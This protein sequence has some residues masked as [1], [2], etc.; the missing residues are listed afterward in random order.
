MSQTPCCPRPRPLPRQT[1]R[2]LTMVEL[3][4]CLCIS[5]LLL[6]GAL[7]SLRD[8]RLRQTLDA[9]AAML[10][11]DVQ[12]ARSLARATDRTVRLAVQATADGGSCYVIHSGPAGACSCDASGAARCDEPAQLQR[13]QVQ[14]ATAG[15]RISTASRSLVF[16][17]GKGTVTPTAT[18]VV[19]DSEGRALHQI[20]NVLGRTRSCSPSGLAGYRRCA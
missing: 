5:G 17:A 16:D 20:V 12:Y 8:L 7:P 6:A 11:T 4:C 10:E 15:V 2:G 3:L 9:V 13:V 14:A 18:F 19:T 1:S